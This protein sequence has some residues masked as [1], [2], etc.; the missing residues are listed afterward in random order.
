MPVFNRSNSAPNA[1]EEPPEL[2]NGFKTTFIVVPLVTYIICIAVVWTMG[3]NA[4][5]RMVISQA[6]FFV[7]E[8]FYLRWRRWKDRKL[9]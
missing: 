2:P 4:R 5:E 6:L 7:P 8:L 3:F 9:L 1:A